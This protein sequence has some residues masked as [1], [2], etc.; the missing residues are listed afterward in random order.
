[1]ITLTANIFPKVANYTTQLTDTV[2]LT[3]RLCYLFDTNGFEVCP[4]EKRHAAQQGY[5]LYDNVSTKVDWF[6]H[7]Y[8][9][10]SYGA[11]LNHSFLLWRHGVEDAARSQIQ[12]WSHIVPACHKVLAMRPKWG[13]DFSMDWIGQS[14]EIFEILHFEYDSFDRGYIE[15]LKQQCDEKFLSTDWA[16]VASYVFAH[17]EQWQHLD[18]RGQSKWKTDLF[19]LAPENFGQVIWKTM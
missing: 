11:V 3:P 5:Q 8:D 17:R 1:M 18:F 10:A 7:H 15:Q 19:G 16:D 14:G 9:N 12:T 4:L 13:I 6:E 2:S